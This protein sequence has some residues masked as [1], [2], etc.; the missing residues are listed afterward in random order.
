MSS[1]ND[2]KGGQTAYN[3]LDFDK[4]PL[5]LVSGCVTVPRMAWLGCHCGG[6]LEWTPI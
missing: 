6:S 3:K 4:F 2:G 1:V 5:N